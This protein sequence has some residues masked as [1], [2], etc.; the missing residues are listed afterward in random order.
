MDIRQLETFVAIAKYK[1]FC[2]AAEHLH[3]TQ[4]TLSNHLK[5]LE[6]E[7]GTTLINRSSSNRKISL[8]KTGEILYNYALSIINLKKTAIFE[9]GKFKGE[10]TGNIEIATSTV[11]GQYL[12]PELISYFKKMYPDITF[13]IYHYDTAEIVDAIIRGDID[14]GFVGGK[15]PNNQLEY[16]ELQDDE[17]LL[18]TPYAK[19][20]IDY[21]CNEI[22]FETILNQK[23]AFI[24]RERGSGTRQL[25]ETRLIE[26]KYNAK[27]LN[28]VAY[29]ENT[30]TIKQCIMRGLG[31]SFLSKFAIEYEVKNNLLN[32]LRIKEFKLDRK[33]YFVYHKHRSPSPVEVEFRKFACQFKSSGYIL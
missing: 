14:F 4:P 10:V 24:L 28:I 3:L 6:K 33:I 19:P 1:H 29:I 5:N 32:A 13:L 21:D 17:L 2:K 16:V 22:S 23:E 9:L 12:V 18:V 27:E 15:I 8:T 30:E 26:K 7:L 20:Y 25:I 11:P 31:V